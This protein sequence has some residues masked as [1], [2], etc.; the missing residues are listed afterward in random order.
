[1]KQ[2]EKKEELAEIIQQDP[3]KMTRKTSKKPNSEFNKGRNYN[4]SREADINMGSNFGKAAN[5]LVPDI[6]IGKNESLETRLKKKDLREKAAKVN[7][8]LAKV[9]EE[10]Q[11]DDIEKS[12]RN[13]IYHLNLIAPENLKDIFKDLAPYCKKEKEICTALVILII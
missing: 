8:A 12:K 6:T 2:W 9:E 1:M 7:Y 5:P 11:M 10:N 13:I 3:T 4:P